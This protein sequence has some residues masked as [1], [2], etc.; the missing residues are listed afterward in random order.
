MTDCAKCGDCCDPVAFDIR[1]YKR[2]NPEW[3]RF[4]AAADPRTDEGWSE[5][6]A[7]GWDDS[8]RETRIRDWLDSRFITANWLPLGD[9]D[10]L[11][12]A[13]DPETRLCMAHD[14]RPPVCSS[15]PWYGRP[16][17]NDFTSLN[18]HCSFWADLPADQRPAEWV[19]VSIGSSPHQEA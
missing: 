8:T 7:V 11:C 14:D 10:S 2:K 16:P 4:A 15:F 6:T 9:G 19:S 1:A 18:D 3:K 12:A 5:W 13:F 17:T